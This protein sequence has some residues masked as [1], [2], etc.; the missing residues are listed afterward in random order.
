[1]GLFLT[2][3]D[4]VFLLN[5]RFVWGHNLKFPTKE[6]SNSHVKTFIL[7]TFGHIPKAQAFSNLCIPL[8]IY[9]RVDFTNNFG[10]KN[11]SPTFLYLV[12]SNQ[13]KLQDRLCVDGGIE[14]IVYI[15]IGFT[16]F[17]IL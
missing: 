6:I 8:R 17:D 3:V 11:N 7:H 15:I 9:L 4:E 13:I 16:K 2:Q 10:Y 5:R 12:F 14:S 1:M